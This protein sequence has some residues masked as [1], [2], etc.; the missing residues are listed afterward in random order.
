LYEDA[1]VLEASPFFG[2]LYETFTNAVARP[3]QVTG[4]RYNQVSSEF[5]NA[6]HAVLSGKFDAAASLTAL[7]RSLD[8]LSRG[9]RW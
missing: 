2:E 3:S 6:V 7:E 4:D 5:F 8:R 9:G 1:H